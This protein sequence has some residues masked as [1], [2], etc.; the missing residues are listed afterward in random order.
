M[1]VV[2]AGN[3]RTMDPERPLAEAMALHGDRIVAVGD[4]ETVL[5]SCPAGTP[6]HDVGTATVLPG[7]IDAH[8]HLVRGGVK[9]LQEM[10]D[11]EHPLADFLA[12]MDATGLADDPDGV[13]VTT[14]DRLA[15]LRRI[16]PLLHE[17]GLTGVIDPA[18]TDEEVAAYQAA[19]E[20]GELTIRVVAMP[21]PDVDAGVD[22]AIERLRG[23]GVRTGFGDDVLRLGGIKVYFDGEGM[24]SQALRS[25][26]WPDTGSCG[27]QRIPSEEFARLAGFCAENGWSIGV[28]AVGDAAVTAV[29]AAFEAADATA[30]IAGRQWQIIHGY[31]ET[32]VEAMRTAA[33]LGV[34][35]SLQPSI[36]LRNAAGL[37]GKLGESAHTLNPM[38]SWLD[39]GARVALG[40][41]GPFFPFD[42]RELIHSAVTRRM[43]GFDAPLAPGE[44][45]TMEEALR[46][47]TSAAAA[48]SFAGDRRGMLRAG[49]LADWT[50]FDIDP[51]AAGPEAFRN[52][53][54]LQTAVGGR[55]VFPIPARRFV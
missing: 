34:V 15:G 12:T 28:H 53:R 8:L 18:A 25:T 45:I 54:T 21:Y 1:I 3:L 14:A 35:A 23:I 27:Y 41:D 43:R 9:L 37:V 13:P 2:V 38:R 19:W 7:L 31:L 40:S 39:A 4:R 36:A 51:V 33:R 32:P 17:L 52:A 49:C 55:V 46:G 42:P 24:K 5:A 16:Q 11:A 20:A 50:V 26:P 29:V 30:S 6:V 47:Y 44:A 48:A 22:A 10:G